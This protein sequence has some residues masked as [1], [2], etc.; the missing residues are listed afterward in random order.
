MSMEP[1]DPF[2]HSLTLREAMDRL[3]QDSFIRPSGWLRGMNAGSLALDVHED[4]NSYTIRASL[5]G[6][7]PEDVHVQVVGDTITIRG[8]THE[9]REQKDGGR[10]I[11]HERQSGSFNRTLTL[12]MPIDGDHAEANFEN[13]VLVLTL[14]KEPRAR[15]RRI[16]IRGATSERDQV[17]VENGPQTPPSSG[18]IPMPPPGAETSGQAE[19]T[20]H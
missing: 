10:V 3:L 16:Q 6:I 15:P 14:P 12:P 8:E 13:G 9:E 19:T 1:W 7:K 11:L 18:A 20:A 5:P 2:G 17:T 4:E